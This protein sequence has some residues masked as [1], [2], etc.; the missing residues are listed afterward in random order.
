MSWMAER[1][2][3][4]V[5]RVTMVGAAVVRETVI[6]A[7]PA[8]AVVTAGTRVVMVALL[9]NVDRTGIGNPCNRI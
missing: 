8:R 3:K 5:K 2:V 1:T 6:L 4:A 7:E 9:A